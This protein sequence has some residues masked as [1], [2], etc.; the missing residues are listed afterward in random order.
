VIP[1]LW[2][3]AGRGDEPD[4]VALQRH[5]LRAGPRV[6][7][8]AHLS[9][10]GLPPPRPALGADPPRRWGPSGPMPDAALV[11][12]IRAVLSG[13]PFHGEGHRAAFPLILQHSRPPCSKGCG[14]N[15]AAA[16]AE[17]IRQPVSTTAMSSGTYSRALLGATLFGLVSDMIPVVAAE[18]PWQVSPVRR[19]CKLK[20]LVG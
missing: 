7:G 3:G 15:R 17:S 13:S 20:A 19:S 10:H 8:L 18:H 6:P 2:P 11:E 4:R 14:A 12:A 5:P 16:T 1:A 9:G